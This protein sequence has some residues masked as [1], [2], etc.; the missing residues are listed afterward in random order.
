MAQI[1]VLKKLVLVSESMLTW[2][3]FFIFVL[4]LFSH[5]TSSGFENIYI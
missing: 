2:F 4:S 3:N 1:V 5:L